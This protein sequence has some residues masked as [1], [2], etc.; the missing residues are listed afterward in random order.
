MCRRVRFTVW[1]GPIRQAFAVCHDEAEM[2]DQTRDAG[3]CKRHRRHTAA[4]T[5]R[6]TDRHRFTIRMRRRYEVRILGMRAVCAVR[7]DHDIVQP[8]YACRGRER[9]CAPCECDPR[10]DAGTLSRARRAAPP[11][12][13]ARRNLRMLRWRAWG[14]TIKVTGAPRRYSGTRRHV[15]ACPV[16][17]RVRPH[18]TGFCSLLPRSQDER[19]DQPQG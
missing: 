2:S 7:A 17:R 8:L 14:L 18:T 13:K 5:A 3:H 12:E 19:H 4:D 10:S 15:P 9:D 16:D 6:N 11:V 1:L